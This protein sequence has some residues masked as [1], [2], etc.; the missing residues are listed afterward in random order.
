ME[1]P[2]RIKRTLGTDRW[3]K[4]YCGRLEINYKFNKLT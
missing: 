3:R 1:T 4:T 2:G